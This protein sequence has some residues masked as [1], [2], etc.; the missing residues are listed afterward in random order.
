MV[1]S[2]SICKMIVELRLILKVTGCTQARLVKF[3]YESIQYERTIFYLRSPMVLTLI[4][5]LPQ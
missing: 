1:V 3:S 4:Q 2:T 5:T